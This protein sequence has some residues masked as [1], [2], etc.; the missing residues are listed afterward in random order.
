MIDYKLKLQGK[1]LTGQSSSERGTNEITGKKLEQAAPA[2]SAA[3]AASGL[4]GKWEF[5]RETQQGTRTNTLTVKP[6]MTATYSMRDNEIPVTDLKVEGDQVS[7]KVTMT[8]NEQ[9]FPME[10]KGKLEGD[11]PQRHVHHVQRRPAGGRQEG[12]VIDY[13]RFAIDDLTI[14]GVMAVSYRRDA[15]GSVCSETEAPDNGTRQRNR[16][17]ESLVFLK[18]C[19]L[20]PGTKTTSS[21]E[22]GWFWPS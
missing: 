15:G 20:L 6:D 5:T 1:T 21:R 9:S 4:V 12:T 16:R 2:V 8:F 18:Q 3:S 14:A 19:T 13:L 7:F 11:D 17:V 22:I 10:F